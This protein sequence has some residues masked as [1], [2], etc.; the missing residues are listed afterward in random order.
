ML[1]CFKK[2]ECVNYKIR[3]FNCQ[4]MSH[5]MQPYPRFVDKNEH[6]RRLTILLNDIQEDMTKENFVKYLVS[7]GVRVEVD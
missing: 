1:N 5:M 7:N 4:A 3:C 2:D 6:E